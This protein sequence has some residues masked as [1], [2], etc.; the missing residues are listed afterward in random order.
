MVDR[1][2]LARKLDTLKG[3][4]QRLERYSELTEEQYLGDADTYDLAERLL[5]LSIE[6]MLDSCQHVIADLRLRSPETN[7][8]VFQSLLEGQLLTSEQAA[9]WRRWAGF[10]NILVHLYDRIDHRISYRSIREELSELTEFLRW[11]QNLL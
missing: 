11:A 7:A 3:Y 9:K 5:H 6:C 8:D 10:R 4:I 2:I 1:L